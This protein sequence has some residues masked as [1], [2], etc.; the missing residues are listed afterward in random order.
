MEAADARPVATI[1][2]MAAFADGERSPAELEQ[3]K[4]ILAAVGGDSLDTVASQMATDQAD[5]HTVAARLSGP[6]ARQLAY[7]MAL[8][9]CHADGVVNA[10]E[11]AFLAELKSALGLTDQE[12][13][14]LT[15]SAGALASAPIGGPL[16]DTLPAGS[17]KT[18]VSQAGIPAVTPDAAF[19]DLILKQAMLTAALELLPERL[20]SLAI[21]PLQMRL[22]YRIGQDY[23]HSLDA[24][25]IKDLAGTF[26][27]GA[28][29][30]VVQ[31]MVG[32]VL[33]GLGR[34]LLGNMLGGLAGGVT[35]TAA[36]AVTTFA[37]TYAL[38]HAARQYY[39]Q[40]RRLSQDDLR[41]LFS[42]FQEDAKT[43]YPK[44]ESQVSSM[45]SGLD[46]QKV[47]GQIR[48]TA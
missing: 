48:G 33:G 43:I 19:D 47:L 6:D 25:Q 26:G 20:A 32:R 3:L 39:A 7:E 24:D 12:V 1:A 22:V 42:Q 35:N 2:M 29:A 40:G 31:G 10:K 5:L 44:I 34:G 45:A 9:V 8:G 21:V 16:P 17:P 11:E 4:R 14:G 23:G 30:Q 28:A 13:A 37:A 38:G 36:Q 18:P 27:I 15:V 41:R 46:L